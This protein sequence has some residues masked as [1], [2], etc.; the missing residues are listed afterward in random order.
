MVCLTKGDPFITPALQA[1]LKAVID[2]SK[3]MIQT[4]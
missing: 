3:P 1:S 2:D 4:E